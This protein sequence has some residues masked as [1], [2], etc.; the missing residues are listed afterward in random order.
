MNV[1]NQ[2]L[3]PCGAG[4]GYDRSGRCSFLPSDGGR[5]LVCARLDQRFLDFTRSRGNALTGLK[6]GDSWCL[7]VGRWH[8]AYLN[9][10]A[11][12]IVLRSTNREALRG[13][14]LSVLQ[15]YGV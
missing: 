10:R 9:D 14:P 3:E 7:C 8:E 5:H 1:Y 12:K 15:K 2:P 4:T 13:V 6:A 11:P